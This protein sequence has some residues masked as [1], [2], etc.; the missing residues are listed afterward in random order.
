LLRKDAPRS[1]RAGVLFTA[2]AARWELWSD[3]LE[4]VRTGQAVVERAFGKNVFE[5]LQDDAEES[6]IVPTIAQVSV[7]EALAL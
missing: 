1:Q 2:G 4:S 6:R 5:R 7:I 3:F